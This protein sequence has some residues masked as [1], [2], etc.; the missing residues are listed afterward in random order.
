M[1]VPV[2]WLRE[3]VPYEGSTK[4][5]VDRLTIS[6]CNVQR[7]YRR[8]VVDNDVVTCGGGAHSPGGRGG[9]AVRPVGALGHK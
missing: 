9:S 1:R 7:V 2:S 3:Y 6:T 8:G 4:E 5:L